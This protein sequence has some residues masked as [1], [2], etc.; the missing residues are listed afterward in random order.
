MSEHDDKLAREFDR[1]AQDGTD[2]AME[3]GH[4]RFTDVALQAWRIGPDSR[5]LDVGCGNGWTVRRLME[6]GAGEGVGVDI[7]AEMVAL[8]QPPGRYLQATADDL[9]LPDAHF[10]HVISVEALYYCAD[11]EAALREWARVAQPGARLMVLI[12]LY[13]ENPCHQIWRPLFPFEVQIRGEAEWAATIEACGWS[14]CTRRRILDPRGVR[15]EADFEPNPWAPSYT[16]YV[17]EKQAGTLCLE[18]V[19]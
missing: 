13:R 10:S 4:G 1:W 19:R 14:D 7:S 18:A 15:A 16:D 3:R 17:A 9:P 6:L 12:D 11:P 5:V 8:A 2:R